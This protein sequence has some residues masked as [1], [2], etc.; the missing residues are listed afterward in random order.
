[1]GGRP[2]L[3][4]ADPDVIAVAGHSIRPV[5]G[6]VN[7]RVWQLD[8]PARITWTTLFD[9]QARDKDAACVLGTEF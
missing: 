1:M 5:L 3:T 4:P 9:E 2:E 8:P 7:K 6:G